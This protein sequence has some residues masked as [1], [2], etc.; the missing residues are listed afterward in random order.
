MV[1]FHHQSL[2]EI[3]IIKKK[4]DEYLIPLEYVNSKM[5]YQNQNN[6]DHLKIV[7]SN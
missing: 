7:V 3:Y 2:N 6:K 5:I 4:E 1:E